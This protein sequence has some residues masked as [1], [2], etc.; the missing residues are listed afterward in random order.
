MST[1]ASIAAS[2]ATD[3]VRG[4]LETGSV[5]S[6]PEPAFRKIL[7]A[8]DFSSASQAAFATAVGLCRALGS[9]LSVLHVFEEADVVASGPGD[10]VIVLERLLMEAHNAL[11]QC[12]REAREAGVP[13]DALLSVGVAALTIECMIRTTR[14]DLAVLGTHALHGVDRLVFG[15]TAESV[16]RQTGCPVLTV[17]PQAVR[18]G[19][20]VGSGPVVFATDFHAETMHAIR[21]AAAFAKA[22][23]SALHCLHVLPRS[24]ETGSRA[25][26]PQILTDA[27]EHVASTSDVLI[28][29][30]LCVTTFGSEVSYALVEYARQH[31]A[32]LIVLGVRHA[33]L[34]ASHIPAHIAYR[35]ITEAT[36]AVLT[37]A[38]PA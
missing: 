4:S 29:P 32:R 34:L 20:T 11:A 31:K 3:A 12:A 15:S 5:V 14:A 10:S 2:V 8:T 37:I 16:L 6:N 35:V 25:I 26:I 21:Y 7:V 38:Y 27:L 1:P 22:S 13:C 33:S 9:T 23:G 36:C 28:D 24:L 30:P 19:L 17:G 18:S